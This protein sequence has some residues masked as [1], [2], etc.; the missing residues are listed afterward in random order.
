MATSPTVADI[1][2]LG[3]YLRN[4]RSRVDP[5]ALGLPNSRRRTPGLRREEVAQRANI[6]ATWYTWL[7]QGRGGAPSAKVLHRITEALMM[8]EVERE[9]AFILA[10]GRAPE[11]RY[12]PTEGVTP[13]L[14]RVLDA[15]GATPAMIRN[16]MWDVIAWNRAASVVLTDYEALEPAERNVLRRMFL[17]PRF[18]AAQLDWE[19]V[20]SFIVAVFRAD[21]ARAGASENMK[22]LADELCAASTD[23]AR[24]WRDNAVQQLGEGVKHIRHPIAGLLALEYSTFIVDGRPDLAM[25]VYSPAN[26]D[27]SAAIG[28]LMVSRFEATP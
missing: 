18:K 9:H 14:Q 12:R 13:R 2:S 8:T 26:E 3:T 1:T 27:A 25:L 21:A 24:M 17:D 10:L 15:F 19:S 5:A 6:S 4:C 22:A 7:E 16:A 28:K 23:F 20:A 11:I